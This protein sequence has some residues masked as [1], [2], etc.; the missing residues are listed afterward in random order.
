MVT[1]FSGVQTSVERVQ[2]VCLDVRSTCYVIHITRS[3]QSDALERLELRLCPRSIGAVTGRCRKTYSRRLRLLSG[4]GY[5]VSVSPWLLPA[6]LVCVCVQWLL[7]STVVMISCVRW[8]CF[9]AIFI[10]FFFLFEFMDCWSLLFSVQTRGCRVSVKWKHSAILLSTCQ[11]NYNFCNG[12]KN[13]LWWFL[14]SWEK[15]VV[16]M[17]T[18]CCMTISFCFIK[19][20]FFGDALCFVQKGF[21]LNHE[22]TVAFH[23]LKCCIRNLF[24]IV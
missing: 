12:G 18:S 6:E 20:I 15:G 10:V 3:C 4:P 8:N 19:M 9:I 13:A 21:T 16:C 7:L 5:R 24:S 23:V 2:I 1:S 14:A 22:Q 17:K 11:L